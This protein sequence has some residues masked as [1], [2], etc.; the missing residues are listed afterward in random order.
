MNTPQ[1]NRAKVSVVIP[2]RNEEA[3]IGKV[4]DNILD[5]DYPSELLEVFAVDGMSTDRTAS[6]IKEYAWK[7]G[8]I[9]YMENPDRVVPF[10]LNKAIQRSTG[11]IIV[12]MDAHSE[13]PGDYISSLAAALETYGCDN[14]GGAWITEPGDDSLKAMAIADATSHPFG[15]GNAYYRLETTE[16]RKVDT[17]PYGCYK[18]EVFD[19]IGLFDEELARN[20]DDEFNAR[21]IR[22]GGIIYLIP[23]VKI[24]YYARKDFRRM[25]RM[26][27]QYGLYKPLVNIKVGSPASLRQFV[28]PIFTLS[29][30]STGMLGLLYPVFWGLFL[31]VLGSYASLDLIV[32]L[33]V[34]LKK[35]R[36]LGELPFLV[37][38]FPLIHLSYGLGYLAGLIRFGLLR[39]KVAPQSIKPSR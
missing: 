37:V 27:Y 23:R 28:P 21:L 35:S 1:E 31:L 9:H 25:N 34:V 36:P 32:S 18:K 15:I 4:L 20:Q 14:A 24:R 6:I 38:A 12:R 30:L 3:Y 29:L 19:R 26:F 7:H 10:A 22:E 8:H 17:V 2:C 16:P 5:Q 33:R 11:S 13:Y 39:K